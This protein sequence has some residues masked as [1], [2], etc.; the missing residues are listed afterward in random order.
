[1]AMRLCILASG[2]S[3]NSALLTTEQARVLI[4]VGLSPRKLRALLHDAGTRLEEI[5]AVFLTH[6]HGDHAGG[7]EGLAKWPHIK[8][9]A[10][11]G[12]VHALRPRLEHSPAWQVFE[13]GSR[14]RHRDLEIDAFPVP[15]DAQDPVGFRFST[16]FE[17]DLLCP[18]HSLAW[19]T[20]LGHVTENVRDR[21]REC[22][23][24]VIE[25]NHCPVMLKACL[26]RPWSTKQRISGRHG[27]LSN[28][29]ARDLLDGVASPRWR[30]VFLTHLS[31]DCNSLEAV[32]GALRPLRARLA[33]EFRVVA[34]G[35]ATPVHIL[36]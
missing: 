36:A 24:L 11:A 34:P 30:N 20:D 18:R 32:E 25:A 16:G 7:L 5:D 33:C 27:H 31:R 8:V 22:D 29:A 26:K 21:V 12:T 17:D 9:F 6:E 28:E 23:T 35:T 3:G 2:S 1:M 14:F 13:T 15:H 10:N 4:D 19:L